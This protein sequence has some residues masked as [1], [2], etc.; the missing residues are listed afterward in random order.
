MFAKLTSFWQSI[1]SVFYSGSNL[2]VL[3][4]RSTFTS[5]GQSWNSDYW[6]F[7]IYVPYL[8]QILSAATL[9]GLCIFLFYQVYKLIHAFVGGFYE[10]AL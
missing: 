5:S 1:L 10:D 8:A 4:V 2:S 7:S 9:I 6:S 3:N